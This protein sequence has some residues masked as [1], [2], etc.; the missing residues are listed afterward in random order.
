MAN[1]TR[2]LLR[3]ATHTQVKDT[4]GTVLRESWAYYDGNPSNTAL[5]TK[6]LLTRE[7]IARKVAELGHRST[8]SS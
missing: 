4:T 3:L 7:E 5:P 1:P 2:W 6:G 8:G